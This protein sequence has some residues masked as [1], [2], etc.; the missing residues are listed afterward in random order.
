MLNFLLNK[1]YRKW[2]QK[3]EPE[4]LLPG[5]TNFN[6]NQLFFIKFAQFWCESNT[7]NASRDQL[8]DNHA[9]NQYR[10]VLKEFS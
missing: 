1:A 8:T 6:Q 7:E 4:P 9:P 5:L 10:F 2:A 3:N